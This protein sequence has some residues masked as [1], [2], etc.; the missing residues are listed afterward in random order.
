MIVRPRRVL[1]GQ[2][3][4]FRGRLATLP[5]PAGGKLIELQAYVSGRWQTFTTTRSD[6][7]G[8]FQAAYR[9]QRTRGTQRYRFRARIP[10]EAGYPFAT[11]ASGRVSVLVKGR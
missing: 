9:F 3:V 2:T 10:S 11:G 6:Q 8:R 1:N 4:T 5:V 7:A